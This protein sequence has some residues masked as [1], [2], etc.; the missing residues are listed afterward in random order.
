MRVVRNSP[1]SLCL[2]HVPWGAGLVLLAFA[3]LPVLWGWALAGKGETIGGLVLVAIGLILLV[4]CFGA[5]VKVQ[6]VSLDRAAN[7]VTIREGGL[8]GRRI[9]RHP[10]AGIHGATL[11]SML[12]KRKPGDASDRPGRARPEPRVWR[13]ALVRGD[14]AAIP[15]SAAYGSEATARAAAAAINAWFGRPDT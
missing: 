9:A 8:L 12:I 3:L 14:G 11:Q 6:S 2:R 1:D 5:F 10:L 13:A 4:G 15:L 7:L